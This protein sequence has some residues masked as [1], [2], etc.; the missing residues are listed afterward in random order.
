MVQE[1]G[2]TEPAQYQ[3]GKCRKKQGLQDEGIRPQLEEKQDTDAQGEGSCHPLANRRGS[4]AG[5]MRTAPGRRL[6]V[7]H[8]RKIGSPFE[9]PHGTPGCRNAAIPCLPAANC[10]SI[11]GVV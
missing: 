8:L 7:G 4:G 10:Q 5:S 9:I 2:L 1:R 6:S 11:Q 3:C